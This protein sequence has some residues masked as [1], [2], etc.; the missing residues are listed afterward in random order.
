MNT[1]KKGSLA[2]RRAMRILEAAGYLCT[3]SGGSFGIFDVIAIGRTDVR[4]VQV[5]GG[6][7]YLSGLERE[8]IQAMTLPANVTKECWRFPNRCK[9]PLIE[10]LR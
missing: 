5:K 1:K 9:A 7:T 8:T 10:I 3:K 4:C 6:G 2:E